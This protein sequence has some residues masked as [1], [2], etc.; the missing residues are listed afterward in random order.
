VQPTRMP[1]TD[2][3]AARAIVE[4]AEHGEVFLYPGDQHYFA[5]SSLPGYDEEAARLVTQRS[6]CS[7]PSATDP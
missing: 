7:S 4:S 3:E 2:L 6:W 1:S 5:D